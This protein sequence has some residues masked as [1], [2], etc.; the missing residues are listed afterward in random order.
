VINLSSNI[1]I[2]GS[3]QKIS[4]DYV[5]EVDIMTSI[6]TLTDTA[7]VTFPRKLSW[8]GK[9][10]HD[11]IHRNDEITID[12]GYDGKNQTVFT[13]FVRNVKSGTP[14]QL[15]CEDRMWL[16]KQVK[17]P[18]KHYP[19]L[20]L[21]DL[22]A[23]HCPKSISYQ[24]TDINLGEFKISNE[25]SFTQVLEYIKSE[26]PLNFFFRDGI[27]YGITPSLLIATGN[28]NFKTHYFVIGENTVSDELEYTLAEDVKIIIKAK[29]MTKDNKKLEVQEPENTSDGQVKT[30]LCHWAKNK[31]DLKK[32]AQEKLKTFKVD[33]MTGSLT[34]FGEPFVRKGDWAKIKDEQNPERSGKT[35][36]IKDVRYTFGQQGYRQIIEL[37][38]QL[39]QQ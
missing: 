22:F 11:L 4:F 26:Y 29:T 1:T 28:N 21:K 32:F 12:L 6:E 39:A 38:S 20:S 5:A 31:D 34:I 35:F 9:N 23:A 15:Q 25:P 8:R 36:V 13:G 16:C 3:G 14:L 7:T 24:V 27:L 30:F 37:G 10:L 2:K 17:L 19:K 18:K 33:Q